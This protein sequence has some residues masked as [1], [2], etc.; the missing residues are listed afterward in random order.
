MANDK[1]NQTMTTT[2]MQE[3]IAQLEEQLAQK[4]NRT[5]TIKIAEESGAI[6]V[7]G[8]QNQRPVTLYSQQ[9]PRLVEALT[10]APLAENSPLGT[11]ISTNTKYLAEKDDTEAQT[12]EKKTLRLAE[13]HG[14]VNHPKN[15]AAA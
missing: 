11:F 12:K 3:R 5:I 8:I 10:G 9:W 1:N 14:V 2:Q 13:A 7:Y 6:S 15:K 4:N